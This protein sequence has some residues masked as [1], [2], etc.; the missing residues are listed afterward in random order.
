[1]V[2]GL[3]AALVIGWVAI[4]AAQG[5][6]EE[7]TKL[8]EE[9]RALAKDGKYEE[10]CAKFEKSLALDR[11]PG[12]LLN[13]GD[14]HEHLGHLGLAWRLYDE[15]ARASD[16]ENNADRAKYA[17]E[18][19]QALVPKTST[20]VVRIAQKDVATVSLT[21]NGEAAQPAVEVR[22]VV[23]PGDVT[24]EVNAPGFAGY[25][26]T[27]RGEAGLKLVF[28]VP[29]LAAT[30]RGGEDGEGTAVTAPTERRHS[31]VVAAYT[32]GGVGAASLVTGIVIGLTARS[33]YNAEFDNGNCMKGDPP[34]CI[35]IGRDNQNNAIALANI[36]TVFGIGGLALL[37]GGAVVFLT[38]PRDVVV[39]PTATAQAGG[40]AV[41]GRF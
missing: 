16:K 35:P 4:A 3:V 40:L 36:G 33:R 38:A 29:P 26:K 13:Y 10:A 21:I 39:I 37:A 31:R 15:A 19:A 30:G 11:A 32:L 24:V 1:M 8:F 14:C 22:E 28:E 6:S 9:G 17:R 27:E 25:K 12:T 2:R 23:D 18:R 7:S 34:M 41:V 20:V 5:P